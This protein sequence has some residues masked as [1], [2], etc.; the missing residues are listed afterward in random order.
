LSGGAGEA[1]F[2]GVRLGWRLGVSGKFSRLP[3]QA[4]CEFF[5]A[6]KVGGQITLRH[7]RPGDR[8]QPIGLKSAVKLQDW[9]VNQKIPRAR[10]RQLVV[11]A[12]EP[13]GIFWIEGQRIGENFK[14]TPQ[15]KRRLIWH[16]QRAEM[17]K[18]Q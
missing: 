4:A 10:R 5:D 18:N 1:N 13:G 17:K 16:W 15:T 3:K 14:L 9:F 11:A 2:D 6:D 8:F 12:A 7:W